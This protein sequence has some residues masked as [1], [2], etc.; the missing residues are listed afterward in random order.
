MRLVWPTSQHPKTNGAVKTHRH[1]FSHAATTTFWCGTTTR[2]PSWRLRYS[3]AGWECCWTT[4][5]T[6]CPSTMPWTPSTFT[7]LTFPSCF[8]WHQPSWSGT[9]RWWSCQGC[10][11]LTSWT[12]ASSKRASVANRIRPMCLEWRAATEASWELIIPEG[13]LAPLL[14]L[15]FTAGLKLDL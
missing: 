14:F 9:N 10:P 11:C 5:T 2:S 3:C 13:F 8:Q 12:A 6:P 15:V 7:P 4:T 1:G